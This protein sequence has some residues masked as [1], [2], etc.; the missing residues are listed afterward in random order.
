MQATE[1]TVKSVLTRTSGYLRDVTSHSLQ[2]YRGCGFGNALCGAYCYVRHNAYVTRGRPWGSFLE[3]RTNAA[4]S[5][6]GTV[7]RERKWAR[8]ERGAFRVFL[9]SAT[10]PFVP[11]EKKY[12]VTKSVL[13]AMIK[14]PPDE[15][16]VQTH[17]ASVADYSELLQELKSCARVH[18]TI[19]CDRDRLPGLPAPASSVAARFDAAGRLRAAGL[20]VVITVS[21][22]L[23]IEHPRAFFAQCKECADAVIVDHF[24]GGD[25]SAN[26]SRTRRTLLPKTMEA[27]QAGTADLTYRDRMIAIARD[28]MPG[29]VGVG[30]RGFAG[31][32][33]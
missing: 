20:A 18:I 26:G 15:L 2:P 10:D 19:E 9:S 4:E 32:F 14:D 27:V 11:Q 12:G 23:P 28:V 21:P 30:A 6:A 24:I 16:I 1:T 29:C 25:G 22:L 33:A 31:E 13:R 17:S 3:V 8:R 7:A 5:Y